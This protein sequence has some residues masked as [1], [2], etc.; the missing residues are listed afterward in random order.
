MKLKSFL[1]AVLALA[2]PV[3]SVVADEGGFR[4]LFNGRDLSGWVNVNTHP[5]TWQARDGMIVTTGTPMGYLR[6][7][8]MYENFVFEFEWKHLPRNDGKPGNSGVF[9]WGDPIP[10]LGNGNYTR[11]IEVQ[12]LL[13]LERKNAEGAYTVTS[14]GD[15]FAI[16]GATCV[17][18]RPHPGGAMRAIP[19]EKRTKGFGEWNHYRITARDGTLRLAVNGKEVSRIDQA[20]PRKGYLALESEGN[21]VQFRNLRIKE[22]PGS[23]PPADMVAMEGT[24]WER[25]YNRKDLAGWKVEPEQEG[26]WRAEDWIIAYDGKSTGKIKDL[27]SEREYGDFEMIVDW[28]LPAKGERRPAPIFLPNGDRAVGPDG[29]QLRQEIDFH[30]DSGIYLRGSI[31][32]QVNIWAHP[33]GSGDIT[34]YRNNKKLSDAVRASAIPTARADKK[35]GEWNRFHITMRGEQVTVVLNGVTVID[36]IHLPGVPARGPIALQ[37]HGDPIEFANLYIRELPA[38]QD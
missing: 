28:R 1:V 30:G 9:V 25:L 27:W 6:T 31:Y 29:K 15:I 19:S 7:D 14:E 8:R 37:H 24:G 16:R 5:E 21:A 33:M 10:A 20:V 11:G 23:N 4:P 12:I 2:G 17:P 3:L 13:G 38:S 18:E 26:H 36:R 22:L 35:P 34:G 32:S